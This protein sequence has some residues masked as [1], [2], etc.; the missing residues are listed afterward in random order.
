MCYSPD[1]GDLYHRIPARPLHRPALLRLRLRRL[2]RRRHRGLR[3]PGRPLEHGLAPQPLHRVRAALEHAAVSRI[4][5]AASRAHPPARSA[6]ADAPATGT[7]DPTRHAGQLAGRGTYRHATDRRRSPAPRGPRGRMAA[8]HSQRS[9][10]E[11]HGSGRRRSTAPPS[12]PISSTSMRAAGS[13]VRLPSTT[14][15]SVQP[16][17][18]RV[19][20]GSALRA[21]GSGTSAS[22]PPPGPAEPRSRSSPASPRAACLAGPDA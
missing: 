8:L 13:E 20:A 3:V 17:R 1:G 14:A 12:A 6:P 19:A 16:R 11:A 7:V 10:A 18:R 21:A 9:R 5:P 4:R 2:L 15:R 22:R